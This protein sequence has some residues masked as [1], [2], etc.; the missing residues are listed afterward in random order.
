MLGE[1]VRDEKGQLKG[2][3]DVSKPVAADRRTK[4]KTTV[5]SGQGD[6]EDKKSTDLAVADIA[7]TKFRWMGSYDAYAS[8]F[9]THGT[10]RDLCLTLLRGALAPPLRTICRLARGPGGILRGRRY[11]LWSR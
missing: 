8:G 4:A 10:V 2:S 5:N 11:L 1:V 7:T 6:R 3:N 9:A